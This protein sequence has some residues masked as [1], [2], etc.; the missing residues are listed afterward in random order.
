MQILSFTEPAIA[1]Y[2]QLKAMK[3]NVA[4][5]DLRIA[6]IALEAGGT[7]VTRNLRDFQ[8]IPNLPMENWAA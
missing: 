1:R 8:R 3:L 4:K 6:A 2:E 5:M 7:L